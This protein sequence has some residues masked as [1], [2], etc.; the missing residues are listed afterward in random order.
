MTT[1]RCNAHTHTQRRRR[2][3]NDGRVLVLKTPLPQHG[4]LAL[5]LLAL[6]GQLRAALP[7]LVLRHPLKLVPA[8]VVLVH[9][10]PSGS[11]TTTTQIEIGACPC[12][13][14]AQTRR[15]GRGG[16]GGGGEGESTS[17]ECVFSMT[18]PHQA[19]AHLHGQR[20]PLQRLDR[21]HHRLHHLGGVAPGLAGARLGPRAAPRH[22]RV[23][24][25]VAVLLDIVEEP[26]QALGTD[27]RCSPRHQPHFAL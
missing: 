2:T 26:I 18:P 14:D 7:S 24:A 25:P 10:Q 1:F 19:S 27:R 15:G 23:R 11:F 21:P 4:D 12:R 16:G 5:Q 17:V 20:D 9:H 13:V 22:H 6:L 3:L 8:L